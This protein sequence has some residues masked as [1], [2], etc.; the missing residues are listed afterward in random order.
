[1]DAHRESALMNDD[2]FCIPSASSPEKSEE[3]RFSDRVVY[4]SP[5][6]A[7]KILT[8]VICL[9]LNLSDC[10]IMQSTN[11]TRTCLVADTQGPVKGC[12][13]DI[14]ETCARSEGTLFRHPS[15]L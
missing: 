1:M 14:R 12:H 8:Q 4:A 10:E 6:L 7:P 15:D 5:R 11:A 3:G 9:T 2:R 13:A